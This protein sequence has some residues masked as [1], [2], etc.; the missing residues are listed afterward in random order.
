MGEG[1]GME[2]DKQYM[3]SPPMDLEQ[4]LIATFGQS[5]DQTS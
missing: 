5:D 1:E 2:E 3:Q 4:D